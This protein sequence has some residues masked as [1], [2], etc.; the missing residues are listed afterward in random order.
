MLYLKKEGELH[1]VREAEVIYIQQLKRDVLFSTEKGEYSVKNYR[2]DRVE[3]ELEDRF[4]KC[5]S[6]MIVNKEKID[7]V[8]PGEIVFENGMSVGMCKAASDRIRKELKNESILA[9]DYKS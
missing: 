2:I 8:K 9:W 4:F 1:R 5:H 3:D 6:Y 7:I